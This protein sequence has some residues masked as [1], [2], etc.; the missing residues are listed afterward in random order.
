ML[1]WIS[2]RMPSWI[3]FV[4]PS[5]LHLGST[6]LGLALGIVGTMHLQCWRQTEEKEEEKERHH[7]HSC[8]WW[9]NHWTYGNP[10]TKWKQFVGDGNDDDDY[11][12]FE[13]TCTKA[14]HLDGKHLW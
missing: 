7:W 11:N 5:W 2:S 6:L 8:T 4:L 12:E 10:S 9:S 3:A 1:A 14:S 13:D